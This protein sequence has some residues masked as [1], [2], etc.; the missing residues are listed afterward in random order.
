MAKAD[1]D[2]AIIGGGINGAGIARDAAQ[3][4]LKVI[5]FEK[6]DYGAGTSSK[7]SKLIHGGLRYLKTYEFALVHE[8]VS[9]RYVQS[10]VAP[11]LV[12]PLPFLIPIYKGNKPGLFV[13]NIGL[14]L[15]DLLALFRAH[16]VHKTYRNGKRLLQMEPKLKRDGL[17]GGIEYYDCAT[18][19][20]RLVLENIIDAQ[21]LGATCHSHTAVTDVRKEGDF[22]KVSVQSRSGKKRSVTAKSVITAVG[23]W[24]DIANTELTLSE[25]SKY[26]RA[27][28]GSHLIFPKELLPLERTVTVI[29]PVDERVMFA[30]PW[31]DR[32]VIGTTDTDFNDIPDN[33]H[34]NRADAEY[35]C[36]S[37]NG[38]FPG[39]E[40]TPEKA[41]SSWAGLRPLL[42][43]D[44]AKNESAV[45]REHKIFTQD[46]GVVLMAGG[47][48]TTYR[49]MSKQCV[50]AAVKWLKKNKL[51]DSNAI[52]SSATKNRN[53][54][55]SK[56]IESRQELADLTK[57]VAAHFGDKKIGVHL[58]ETYGV[59]AKKII[60]ICGDDQQLKSRIESDIPYIWGEVVYSCR[61]ELPQTLTDILARRIPLLLTSVDCGRGS[62]NQIASLAAKE[63]SWTPARTASEIASYLQACDNATA[64]K[65]P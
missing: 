65:R 24:T 14:W 27:T 21:A 25:R 45:S 32:T 38:Y 55:G 12:R 50:D 11:H 41:I 26:L 36:A 53:L 29:S 7:S 35:L 56:G 5:L 9:E 42:R 3:R 47:K 49:I 46:D 23:P 15:Y 8:S 6:D 63:L 1:Y 30:I 58:V 22:H 43:D 13:M 34:T 33:C 20:A 54:P 4:G 28:K 40:L 19:D 52:A 44:K 60:A 59:N 61:H 17:K 62:A 48:L 10:K 2:I 39:A 57:T 51:V 37:A 18:D 31:R 64:F 16:K